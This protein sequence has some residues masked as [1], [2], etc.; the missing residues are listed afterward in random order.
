MVFQQKHTETYC[1]IPNNFCT[2]WQFQSN[3]TCLLS[4]TG[5]ATGK[6]HTMNNSITREAS[7]G[8]HT[9]SDGRGLNH[10]NAYCYHT[11]FLLL[12]ELFLC[13]RGAMRKTTD[14]DPFNQVF[15]SPG[16]IHSWPFTK[17]SLVKGGS[18]YN[19]LQESLSLSHC[20]V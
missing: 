10:S 9:S 20:K 6:R 18:Q 1:E 7:D 12:T 8:V 4:D 5:E 19:F 14:Q 3:Q 11:V 2:P 17:G 13:T 15:F 16:C